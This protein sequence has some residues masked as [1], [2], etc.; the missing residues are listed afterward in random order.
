MLNGTGSNPPLM[1]WKIFLIKGKNDLG[2]NLSK[3]L[4][5][6]CVTFR[7]IFPCPFIDRWRVLGIRL[8]AI[9]RMQM[10]DIHPIYRAV[11]CLL[12]RNSIIFLARS[13]SLR[14]ASISVALSSRYVLTMKRSA[15][16]ADK[17][18]SC[19]FILILIC[20]TSSL[21]RS[22]LLKRVVIIGIRFAIF[23]SLT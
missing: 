19:L 11:A 22:T 5:P 23:Q 7:R 21:R 16:E 12:T 15:L 13:R 1:L 9:L 6:F 18:W 2:T 3:R 14:S 10:V 17:T 8:G 20:L 4:P